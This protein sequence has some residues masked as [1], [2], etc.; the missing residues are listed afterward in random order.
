MVY[1][2]NKIEKPFIPLSAYSNQSYFKLYMSDIGLLRKMSRLPASSIF[3]ESSHYTEFK[4][5]LTE[6]Y[7]LGELVNLH[8]EVPF[9]WKSE[10]TAEVDFIAQFEE[11][12]V[13]IEV[14]A[15]T[16]VK[17]RSLTL[18]RDKY[19]PEVSVRTSMLNMKK[20]DNLLSL[21]LYIYFS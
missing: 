4:G 12:I 15:S 7:V 19:K 6:N 5:A 16:N 10:N 9:Y 17:A 8:G 21:P 20:D 18:Y 13:P 1:K 2:V 11:K 14:K 3:D